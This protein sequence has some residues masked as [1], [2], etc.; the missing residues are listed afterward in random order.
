METPN[1]VILWMIAACVLLGGIVMGPMRILGRIGLGAVMGGLGIYIA[2]AFLAP[3]GI[4][5]SLNIITIAIV[6]LLG[7]PGFVML[8]IASVL[9]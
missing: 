1:N 3:M 4:F 5:V 8:Y 7:L 9:I 2:N 6:A